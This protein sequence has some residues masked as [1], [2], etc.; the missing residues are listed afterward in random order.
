MLNKLFKKKDFIMGKAFAFNP[1][2]G[3][4]HTTS[5]IESG[6]RGTFEMDFDFFLFITINNLRMKNFG[7]I[8]QRNVRI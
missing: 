6:T 4:K 8:R 7:F 5:R 1:C 2:D 3:W